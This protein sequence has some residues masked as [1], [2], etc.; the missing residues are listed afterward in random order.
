V[1]EFND[2]DALARELRHGDVAAV[3]GEPAMTN[4]GIVLPEPGF[5]EGVRQLCDETRTLLI[6]DETHTFS[7]GPG[8]ATRR[9]DL[10]PVVRMG[11]VKNSPSGSW[12][13]SPTARTSSTS[14]ASGARWRE[15]R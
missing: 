2:L 11:S 6:L 12:S 9:F 4:I 5:F 8:G 14:G 3:L 15:T 10:R 1:V 13:L 7:A